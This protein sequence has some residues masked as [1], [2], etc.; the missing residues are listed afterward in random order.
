[1]PVARQRNVQQPSLGERLIKLGDVRQGLPLAGP[2][3]ANIGV[4][5]DFLVLDSSNDQI[6]G[7]RA[8]GV[9]F[10]RHVPL[11]LF[12]HSSSFALPDKYTG[13]SLRALEL[14]QNR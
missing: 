11:V 1:M 2:N 13:L 9:A 4:G 6:R 5:S 10:N 8:H 3:H 12:V 14:G 7:H